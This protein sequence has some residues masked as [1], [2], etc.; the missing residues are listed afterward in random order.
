[1]ELEDSLPFFKFPENI[2]NTVDSMLFEEMN[3]GGCL[4]KS[5]KPIPIP[6]PEEIIEYSKDSMGK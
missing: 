2:K 1:M 3:L 5:L 4:G 6:T